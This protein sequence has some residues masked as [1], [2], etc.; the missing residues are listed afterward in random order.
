MVRIMTHDIGKVM[1][2]VISFLIIII[3]ICICIFILFYIIIE[4]RLAN[5]TDFTAIAAISNAITA[6]I[7]LPLFAVTFLYL[8][9]TRAMVDE[10]KKQRS[11]IEEPVVSIKVVP[12]SDATNVLNL[13][14]KNSGGGPAYDISVKFDP[15]LPYKD[16]KTLNQLN[17]FHNMVLLDKGESVE[18]FLASA[19]EYSRSNKPKRTTATL[20]YFITPRLQREIN[21]ERKVRIIEID[22]EER[23]DQLQIRNRTMDDLVQE[24]EELKQGLLLIAGEIK[25]K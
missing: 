16:S 3:L 7:G 20:E 13:V 6:F 9:A 2:S 12:S 17:I 15:D 10:M 18:L 5:S 1:K 22:I 25:N 8:L 4:A 19:P 21:S 11:A 23:K 14:L 24:I